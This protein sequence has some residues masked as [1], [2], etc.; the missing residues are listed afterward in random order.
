MSKNSQLSKAPYKG[1]RD[2]FPED[3]R[4]QE[5]LFSTF[6]QTAKLF[7]MEPYDGP[8]LEPVELYL[9][10]SGQELINEQIYSF[11]DRGGRLVAIRPEMT[12][13][14]ARM[15]AQVYRELPLPIRWYSIPNLMR[16]ERPQKGRLREHWQFNCDIFGLESPYGEIEIFQVIVHLFEAFKASTEHFAIHFNSRELLEELSRK[17]LGL[18]D[19]QSYQFFKL[20]DRSKKISA[21]EFSAELEIF[22]GNHERAK[23]ILSEYFSIQNFG[24][25]TTFLDVNAI[26]A[27][28]LKIFLK[29]I[30]KD[31]YTPL[32]KYLKY[33]PT[34]VR[35]LDY[36][37]GIVFEVFNL[38]PE[39]NRALCGGGAY[40]NLLGIFKE[41]PLRGIGFGL[42]DVT[43][44]DFL[45]VHG[46]LPDFKRPNTKV[47]I[48]AL[49]ESSSIHLTTMANHARANNI[50]CE[51]M[52]GITKMKK[53]FH[54]SETKGHEFILILGD[55]NHLDSVILRNTNSREQKVYK[56]SDLSWTETLK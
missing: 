24:N 38:H 44:K 17:L 41:G 35:G 53:C 55:S 1:C 19:E 23:E 54:L 10:K 14:V 47:L 52:W 11:T 15:I 20:I 26:D 50:S 45:E 28:Q 25:L 56:L 6:S 22:C 30:H 31:S 8:L 21:A 42:G 27:P 49:D 37:T 5:F 36:Y 29:E 4:I 46:L 51:V 16:Y 43:L 33:D 9:A 32:L 48:A 3:K 7:G 13:T 2:L 39:H 12:P 34:I 18:S 40:D